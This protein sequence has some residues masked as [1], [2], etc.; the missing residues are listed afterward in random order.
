MSTRDF[1]IR[2]RRVV[3]AGCCAPASVV[4]RDGRVA[5]VGK[6]EEAG[7]G[8][9]VVEVGDELVL[10]AGLV[11][12]HV[13]VNEPGRTDWEGF[14]TATR[15][16]ARGGVTTV[17][18]MPLNSVP[19]TTTRENLRAKLDAAAGKCAVDV[20]FWGGLVPGNAG[21]LAEMSGE[22]VVGF[23]C[24]LIHSGVE[25]F[26]NGTEADLRAAL[27][28]LARL[29]ATLIAHAETPAP[30]E[31]A[32]AELDESRADPRRYETFLRSRPR[33]AED[34]AVALLVRLCRE[35][36]ASVHVVHHSSSDS[37][38]L[39]KSARDE[40]LPLTAE[41]CP[42]YLRFA[43]EEIADGATEFKCCP[44]VRERENRERLW[45]A[46]GDGTLSMVVSD[47][48]PCPPALKLRE[49][50]DFLRA[51]GGISS[52]QL[53]L[54]VVWTE[55]RARGFDLATLARWLC[56]AP[57]RL[58]GLDARKGAIAKGR[59]ADFVVWNP[60][61]SFTVE[62]RAIE[63]RHKL[64]PYA[65]AT[66]R[67]TVEATYLR[68]ARVYE[69]G[70]GVDESRAGRLLKRGGGEWTSPSL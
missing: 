8:V 66:L 65:G 11:D 41:T 46:L 25:E 42:H 32:A 5:S 35:T 13:H 55:A 45:A 58:A 7:A 30:V 37:L 26:P 53:R 29:G 63:H 36:G 60:D 57:A 49:E 64:T 6:F 33:A 48:S 38:A 54:P 27:P 69:R 47:H 62:P 28:E 51:W 70:R 19:P 24:F 18:D 1:V 59:D 22:G 12:S 34:E 3:T 50:G 52:L 15:A 67:G 17:V 40:G 68:G 16:A 4:V 14:E 39:I 43:A 44:P 9:E 23:K 31:R 61:E 21:A 56:E 2:A 10:M 20:G